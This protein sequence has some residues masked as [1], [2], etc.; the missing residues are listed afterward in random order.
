L[1]LSLEPSLTP[2]EVKA[3]LVA[4]ATQDAVQDAKTGSPNLLL[5]SSPPG[6]APKQRNVPNPFIVNGTDA[7]PCKWKWQVGLYNKGSSKSFCG[8]TLISPTWVVTAA[9][10]VRG[11][12]YDVMA[13]DILP[14]KGQRRSSAR[15]IVKSDAD[16]ALIEL[17]EPFTLNECV[18][19]AKL[20][21]RAVPDDTQCWITGWGR[22]GATAVAAPT[23]Q[24]ATTQVVSTQECRRKMG[25]RINKDDVCVVGNYNGNPT[26]SC[27]GDS[28]GPLVCQTGDD[29]AWAV[30]GATSWGY[31]CD[32]ITVYAGTFGAM[33]WIANYVDGTPAPAPT[34]APPPVCPWY[35]GARTCLT[36]SC[37][38]NCPFCA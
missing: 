28:G 24:Q 26:S 12:S 29:D 5:Y 34:P 3:K 27:Y 20:P 25:S 15:V 2:D 4:G 38:E 17:S 6:V 33:D 19:V 22:L 8:G 32:G 11:T 1:L 9:H 16:F 21:T 35:C 37:K 31:Q 7:E 14:G 23:L 18:D 13:G 10:C 30:Y 36:A